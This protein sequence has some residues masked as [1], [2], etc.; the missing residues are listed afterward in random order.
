MKPGQRQRGAS[1]PQGA[2]KCPLSNKELLDSQPKKQTSPKL[3]NN[4]NP[5][6]NPKHDRAKFR[7]NVQQIAIQDERMAVHKFFNQH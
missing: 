2:V 1:W 7:Q 3:D 5:I 6:K 4:S